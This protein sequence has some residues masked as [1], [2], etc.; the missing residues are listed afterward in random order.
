M[1]GKAQVGESPLR[2]NRMQ[3]TAWSIGG[4]D[5]GRRNKTTHKTIKI[6]D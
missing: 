1:M 3:S 2:L 5:G 6:K 4:T